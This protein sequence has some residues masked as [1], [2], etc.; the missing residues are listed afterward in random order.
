MKGL[1][2]YI[3][4]L[5][6]CIS[7]VV[8]GQ[9]VMSNQSVTD[10][11]GTLTD[12]EDGLLSGHYDNDEDYTFT[13]CVEGAAS[14]TM[15]IPSIRTELNTD[16]LMFFDGNSTSA[17]SLGEY[18]GPHNAV[19]I[20]STGNCLTIRF[21]SDGSLTAQGWDAS[22]ESIITTVPMPDI[23]P[24][25]NPT[26]NSTSIDIKIDQKF[27]C[28]SID[29]DNFGLT[30]PSAP[31]ISSVTGLNCNADNEADSFRINF[32][33]DLSRSGDYSLPFETTFID[34]C[35]SVW[36][37]QDT[38]N[39]SVTDCPIE[40]DLSALNSPI[41]RGSCT[42]IEAVI[43]GGD[44]NNYTY[45][46]TPSTVS[47]APPQTVCPNSTTTYILTVTDGASVPGT[48]SIEVIV[49]DPPT[50]QNDT[51]VCIS[52]SPLNLTA[53]P[54]GGV[55][56][57]NGITNTATGLFAPQIAGGGNTWVYYTIS[58][59]VDSVKVSV[60]NVWTGFPE[61]ACP[62]SAAFQLFG[63][64]AGGV[65]SGSNVN[66]AGMFTP[67][68][69]VGTYTVTYTWNGCDAS[70]D[71]QIGDISFTTKPDSFCQSENDINLEAIPA[72]GRWVG[73]GITNSITGNFD[74]AA[75]GVGRHNITYNI[76]GCSYD[77]WLYV[78]SVNARWNEVLCPDE[79]IVALI[80]G[81]PAGGTWSGRGIV[82]PVLG[83]WD[84]NFRAF[85]SWGYNDTAFYTYQG[86]TDFKRI[87][88]RPTRILDDSLS[89]CI[90]EPRLLLNWEAVRRTPGG[91]VWSGPGVTSS[92]WFTA[93][94]AG[95]GLHTLYYD[96]NTCRDSL[97]ILIFPQSDIQ[98]DTFFCITEPVYD[99]YNG[100]TGGIFSGP[101]ITN[102]AQG[103]FN[104][105]VARVGIHKIYY[106]SAFGC[107]DSL[108]ITVNPRPAV[109]LNTIDPFYCLKD[110][111]IT[112]S[113]SPAGGTWSGTRLNGDI[114]NPE[115]AG[116]GP[117]NITYTFGTPQCNR[118]RTITS[119]VGDTLK[120]S[121]SQDK[122]SICP[123]DG[124]NLNAQATRGQGGGYSYLWNDGKTAADIYELPTTHTR[125]IVEVNDGCSNPAFDTTF[126]GLHPEVIGSFTTSAIECFGQNGWAKVVANPPSNDYTYRWNTNPESFTDS[127][128]V[129]VGLRYR[130]NIVNQRTS[131]FWDGSVMVPGYPRIR[132]NFTTFP[133]I[134]ACINNLNSDINLFDFSDG[135]LNG[136]WEMGD[137][138]RIPYVPGQNPNYDY[139]ADTSGYQ[140]KLYIENQGGCS[141]SIYFDVCVVDTVLIF[142][143]NAFS[144]GKVDGINDVFA[145]SVNG[146]TE[147]SIEI[148]NRW[149]EKIFA[150]EDPRG[151]W[152]G[153]LKG[154]PLPSDYYHYIIRYKGRKTS[155]KQKS[156]VVFLLW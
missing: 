14:I 15:T 52:S 4:L 11:T 85:P 58:G 25:V 17:A 124:V 110:T 114:F 132:A 115:Q 104:P 56:S 5:I 33:G 154:K 107:L 101:G 27:N 79:G 74:P 78:K 99:L 126:V 128:N 23:S 84:V 6:F 46:W 87:F 45:A 92:G 150:T 70:K 30:G 34:A 153:K 93:A 60:R 100:Q 44:A 97:R 105:G 42:D 55:W 61:A 16:T 96:A 134:P 62:N 10:C 83:T 22:W 109:T 68:A 13:I 1:K 9:Y 7:N 89:M 69:V 151:T 141:D 139:A 130:V 77:T 155:R 111:N 125:Y 88:A 94:D 53:S 102:G 41:C 123:G 66:A 51:L 131:C 98:N 26:C 40:V 146:T 36:I 86:C 19:T 50:A 113:Y 129:N 18:H 24:I 29:A 81:L 59:C 138:T 143:P 72:G 144:P 147:Y 39:F 20:T 119:S 31:G 140:I 76:N 71:I 112:L 135:G 145:P 35:D 108:E 28:D 57:G 48:D 2:F 106:T 148:F 91:G 121:I 137:G 47:G 43:T 8:I 49:V 12:S 120:V 38:L 37:L 156:G 65:W 54:A 90:E 136:Y 122:D 152:D 32:S 142:V 103:T 75:A 64:P 80:P 21:V 133:R 116:T 3:F 117:V 95:Y 82:D 149:G 73:N 63:F 118:S 67:P 127:I